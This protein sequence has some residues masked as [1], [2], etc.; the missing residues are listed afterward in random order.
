M[1]TFPAERSASSRV[2]A[3][4]AA[5][6]VPPP[7]GWPGRAGRWACSTSTRP[8]SRSSPTSSRRSTASRPRPPASTSAT[9]ARSAR[10]WPSCR[11]ALPPVVALANVAGVSS[12]TPYLELDDEEWERVLR[13]NL[14]GVHHVTRAVVD[15]MIGAGVRAHRVGVLGLRAARR[16]HVQ[17]DA[18]LGLQGGGHR[19]DPGAGPRARSVR[20]HRQRHRA[21]TDRHRHHGRDAVGRAQGGARRRPAWSTGSAP[22]PT[23][24]RRSASWC[25]RSPGTSPV[26]RS[27]S[28]AAC[29][30]TERRLRERTRA[31]SEE[32]EDR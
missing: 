9:P 15:S 4:G 25:R 1:D 12:P 22:P 31:G 20:H 7:T 32:E 30:C 11:R 27:T 2:R 16:R 29:T 24:P 19:P 13:I 5:S 26:T 21:G 8:P 3:P 18:V 23:S 6:A 28:T 14:D 17:Q 10:R